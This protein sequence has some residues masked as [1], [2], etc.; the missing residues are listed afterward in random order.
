L[1]EE[2]IADIRSALLQGQPLGSEKFKEAMSAAAGARRTRPQRGRPRK[3]PETKQT[4]ERPDCG[5]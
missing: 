3:E 4:E 2:A 1:D 5:F